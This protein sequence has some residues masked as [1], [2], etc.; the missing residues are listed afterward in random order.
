MTTLQNFSV[1][2]LIKMYKVAQTIEFLDKTASVHYLHES[3]S[4]K[5]YF[6]SVL[7]IM[8]N[9]VVFNQFLKETA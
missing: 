3:L 5:Q 9:K 6:D 8:L 4:T 2:L 7:F 1:V